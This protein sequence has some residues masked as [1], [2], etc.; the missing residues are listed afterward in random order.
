[1]NA[2]CIKVPYKVRYDI[3]QLDNIIWNIWIQ[4]KLRS[5]VHYVTFCI[6]LQN[7]T[8]FFRQVRKLEYVERC[9]SL[10]KKSLLI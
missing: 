6:Q 4:T 2:S 10:A 5:S 9:L 7:F 3:F 8:V 1:V